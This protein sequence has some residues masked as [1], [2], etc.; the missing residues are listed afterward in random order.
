MKKTLA[1]LAGVLAV[2]ISGCSGA[3]APNAAAPAQTAAKAQE[4]T[5][6]KGQAGTEKQDGKVYTLKI[7]V[8]ITDTDP[9]YAGLQEMKR[10][11]EEKSGGRLKIELYPSSQLGDTSEVIEQAVAGANVGTIAGSSQLEGYC[12][13]FGIVMGPYIMRDYE[14]CLKLIDSDLYAKWV[15]EIS[16]SGLRLLSFN[17]QQGERYM[18]TKKAVVHPEDMKGLMIRTFSSELPLGA[19]EQAGATG[20]TLAWSEVYSG[21][22][23]K[24][25]DGCEAQISAISGS[26]LTEVAPYVAK[27]GHFQM[28]SGL[29]VGN[30][31]YNSLPEDLQQILMETSIAGGTFASDMVYEKAEDYERE[32]TE[33]GAVFTEVDRDEWALAMDPIYDKLG[34]R[35]LKDQIDEIL[36]R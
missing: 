28:L 24:V 1:L 33:K 4:Q 23:Q 29:V 16:G 27:T 12:K 14:D 18:V 13:D 11:A 6:A 35:E 34:L 5:E 22:Q 15:D 32:L 30:A 19:I 25:I 31:F 36:A 20:S 3:G 10:Q 2:M 21:I 17:Y 7:G 26:A 8:V 9:L